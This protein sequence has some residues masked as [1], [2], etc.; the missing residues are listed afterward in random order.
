MIYP[1][2]R[3][4]DT[5]LFAAISCIRLEGSVALLHLH[6]TPPSITM[7]QDAHKNWIVSC[8][9]TEDTLPSPDDSEARIP[10]R[11]ILHL[12]INETILLGDDAGG[13]S[14]HD[15]LQKMLAKSAFCQLPDSDSGSLKWDDTLQVSPTHWWDGQEMGK[16]SEMPPLYTGW[17]WPDKCCPYYRTNLKKFSKQFVNQHHGSIYKPI[18]ERCEEELAGSHDDHILPAFYR[19]MEYLI[20][21]DQPFTLAFRTF[22]SDVE[23]VANLVTDFARGK[24]PDYPNVRCPQLELSS[25][26]LYQGRWKKLDDGSA[27]YQLWNQDETKLVAS[28]DAEVLRLLDQVT[29]CGIRDDYPYWKENKFDP[30]AGKPVWIPLFT[31]ESLDTPYGHH[32]LFDD[33]IHNLPNDG[34]ACVRRQSVDGKFETMDRATM[35]SETQGLHLVRVP[36]VEPVLNPNWLVEQIQKAQVQLQQKFA[37]SKN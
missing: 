4:L 7:R 9:E 36:T 3:T 11:L 32:L 31:N 15:S 33:N 2:A 6:R 26:L 17:K 24:H 25:D 12:D 10:T 16:E 13:D 28:G 29:V 22:G 34:I 19:T 37:D 21:Q 20:T 23:E 30:T 1:P 18:L 27:V 14:R 5:I 35:H 8:L